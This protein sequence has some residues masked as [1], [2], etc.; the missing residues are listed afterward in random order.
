MQQ[1]VFERY[2]NTEVRY[3]FVVRSDESLEDD[4]ATIRAEINKLPSLRLTD[5][6][7]KHL[8]SMPFFS[9]AYIA[10][11]RDFTFEPERNVKMRIEKD[12]KGRNQ[13]RISVVG[14]WFKTILYEV[15]VLAIVS[16]IRNRRLWGNIPHE[17]FRKTLFNKVKDLKAK[18][19]ERNITNFKLAEMGTRRRFSSVTQRYAVEYLQKM[20]PEHFV[21]TSNV[22]LA[23]EY[24]LKAIGTVAHE[25]FMAHQAFTNV[26]LSQKMALDVWDDVFRGRLGIALTDTIGSGAF[27]EDF[28]YKYANSFSGVRHDSGCPFAWGD[29][30]IAHYESLGIDPMTK[31]LVFTDGL[32]FDKCLDICEYFAGR[33][34]VSFGVGTF[35]SADMG[36]WLNEDETKYKA[37]SIVMKIV[38][39]NG[40]PVAKISDEPTKAICESE[41]Y[42]ANLRERFGLPQQPALEK[43]VREQALTE[44]GVQ[45]TEEFLPEKAVRGRVEFLKNKL[46]E[47][48]LTSYVLGISGGVDS[49]LTGKL[50]QIA[51]DE[52]NKEFKTDKF[53]FLAVRLPFVTQKDEDEAQ[54]ALSF[55][56]PTATH[57][58]NIGDAT[59]AMHTAVTDTVAKEGFNIGNADFHKGNVKARQRMIAQYEIAAFHNGLVIGTDHNAEAITGFFTK[60]GD[61]ACDVVPLRGVNKRQVRLMAKTLGAPDNLVEKAPTADLEEEVPQLADEIALGL[62]Y[63]QIDD[64]LE[65]KCIND[66]AE[67]RL[68]GH[69]QKTMHKRQLAAEFH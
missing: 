46:I 5:S 25:Y 23:R 63:D 3:E 18:L 59:N 67:D 58:V 49:T 8:Q 42:L 37:L 14:S 65:G 64:F 55:I 12:K 52:L 69:Y 9:N 6:E 27:R 40:Q 7:A 29:K 56:R 11:L 21:G 31:T 24:G 54:Q 43:T 10:A 22:Q 19:E 61:G 38:E 13:L 68:L 28:D 35:I 36:E 50:A 47:S 57:T 66:V 53:R 45:P 41:I 33:I 30:F 1:A 60:H 44:L 62:S 39:V 34:D 51:I 4:F 15:K 16:E 17:Q 2:P 32:D 20:I 26:A 48:G